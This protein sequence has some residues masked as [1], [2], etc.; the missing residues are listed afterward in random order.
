M[1]KCYDMTAFGSYR[2]NMLEGDGNWEPGHFAT[3]DRVARVDMSRAPE[4]ILV[5]EMLSEVHDR[6]YSSKRHAG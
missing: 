6:F 2:Y 5:K 4:S 3:P 1:W